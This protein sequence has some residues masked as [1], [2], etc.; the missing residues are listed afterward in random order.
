MAWV[1][2]HDGAMSHPKV[3]GMFDWRDPFHVWIWGLSYCQ[4][5]LTDGFVIDAA[6]PKAGRRAATDLMARGLW[7]AAE[8][9]W[10][11]HD[12]LSWNDSKELVTKK[13]DEARVRMT[14]SRDVRANS[15]ENILR[16]GERTS[17]EVLRG[18]GKGTSSVLSSEGESERKPDARSKRPIFNGQRFVVFEWML[19][20]LMRVLGPHTDDFDLHEWFFTLDASAVASGQ[21][22]PQRDG[23]AWLQAQTLAEARRRGLPIA[24]TVSAAPTLGKQSS[25]LLTAV[26]G[27]SNTR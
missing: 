27:L 12:Y 9:G 5:H 18:L 11:V 4:S 20:D 3:I 21:V 22:V 17:H 13:R 8:G 26:A 7:E 19:D 6:V 10:R 24:Q 25:R 1:R 23:G 16:T 2:I 14:R 15:P